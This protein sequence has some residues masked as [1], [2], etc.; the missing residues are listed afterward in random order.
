MLAPV[1]A[2]ALKGDELKAA[3]SGKSGTWEN[4]DGNRKGTVSYGADG[5]ARLTGSFGAFTE[6]T[7]VWRIQGD[8]FC[9]KWKRL[10]GGKETCFSIKRLPDGSL[11]SGQNIVKLK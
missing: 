4:W 1:V 11:D 5:K 3:F 7:G 8:K 6:D 10:R 2:Q 9:V